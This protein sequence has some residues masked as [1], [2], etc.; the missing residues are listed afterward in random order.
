MNL[1]FIGAPGAGK[2]TQ[3][4]IVAKH[5]NIEHLST[6][7]M[8]RAEVKKQTPLGAQVEEI[9][10]KGALVPDDIMFAL[11]KER[12]RQAAQSGRGFILDGFPRNLAQAETLRGLTEDIHAV[13]EI[14]V[15]DD[16]ILKRVS[17]RLV[18]PGCGETYHTESKRPKKDG[19][20]D[21][22]GE[23]LAQR[24]DDKPET[25][26]KRLEVFHKITEPI[27][28]FYRR[29]KLLV[30]VDGVG[31]VEDIA[32]AIIGTIEKLNLAAKKQPN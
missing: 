2:G 3:A 1:I 19:L 30:S 26:M 22:C 7:D 27:I 13:V 4:A 23:T 14:A 20:C 10:S 5:Y 24:R 16:V 17:G 8:L 6:G 12:F 18:C 25:V 21:A 15:D 29:E 31:G 9:L 11:L 32:N 28:D